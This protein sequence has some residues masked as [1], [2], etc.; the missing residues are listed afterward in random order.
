MAHPPY[1]SSPAL[2]EMNLP[3]SL[4]HAHRTKSGVWGLL[5]MLEG[6]LQLV[7]PETE[8][9]LLV[10]VDSPAPI[11]PQSLHYVRLSGPMKMQVEF[12]RENPLDP[13]EDSNG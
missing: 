2:D 1:G 11:P 4:R 6:E 5:R 9:H 13:T 10:T 3:D 12:Y 7:F 8:Q